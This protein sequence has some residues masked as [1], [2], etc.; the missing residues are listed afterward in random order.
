VQYRSELI[1]AHAGIQS[2][3]GS[4]WDAAIALLN[5]PD[6]VERYRQC[7]VIAG[8]VR[9]AHVHIRNEDHIVL[10]GAE[11]AGVPLQTIA[12]LRAEHA[13]LCSRLATL[14]RLLDNGRTRDD[15]AV[16]VLRLVARFEQH[17]AREERAIASP[18][19]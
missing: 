15:A 14:P 4:A 9:D 6:D 2:A 10:T 3:L 19:G 1:V 8:F 7:A 12:E 11:R 13:A 18:D 17:L 16:E 5:D